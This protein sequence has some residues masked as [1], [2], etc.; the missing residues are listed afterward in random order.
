M[1]NKFTATI[2]S[3]FS[4]IEKLKANSFIR[5]SIN[6][7]ILR[8]I[9]VVTLFGFTLFLTHNYSPKII[10]QYDFIRTFLLVLGSICLLGT[11]QSILYFSG[12]ISGKGTFKD[13]K[14]VYLKMISLIAITSLLF[15]ILLNIIGEKNINTL[16]NDIYIY[17]LI[18]KSIWILFFYCITLLNTET[19]RALNAF[20]TAEIFRNTLKYI[21]VIIGSIV[22]LKLNKTLYLVDSFL[23][24]FVLL[25]II[26][27]YMLFKSFKSKINDPDDSDTMCFSRM[28][29]FKESYPMAISG[30]AFFLL[31]SIDVF[32]IKKYKGNEYVAYYATAIKL[33]TI[34]SMVI[35]S[36]NISVSTKI[37]E[38][39]TKKQF[40]ELSETVKKSSRLIFVIIL[41]ISILICFFS[42]KILDIFG[43]GYNIASRTLIILM[44]G[45]T[46]CSAF[47]SAPIYLNMTGRQNIFQFI[48]V[49]AVIMNFVLN[50]IL[51]PSYGITGAA[52]AFVLSSLFWNF[53]ATIFIYYKDK[54]KVFIH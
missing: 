51:I 41:P 19:F 21:S 14:S 17:P 39:Y 31:M 10:G 33:M 15:L 49:I 43:N 30:M 44:I 25:S 20:N 36:V 42:E 4:I 1:K 32:F 2:S 3:M 47:G 7:L 5:Q 46:I 16:F 12:I 8:I 6:T 13:L 35:I 52:I 53:T 22:L 23:I 27:T 34:I 24:G 29:I 45:Q 26:S 38:Y 50:R 54:I 11:D 28:E 48:L 40:N 18:S 37:A 9:G